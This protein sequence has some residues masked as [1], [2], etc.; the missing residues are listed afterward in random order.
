[1]RYLNL[2]IWQHYSN[3]NIQYDGKIKNIQQI[4]MLSVIIAVSFVAESRAARIRPK[5]FI[6][7]QIE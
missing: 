7:C 4:K 5:V 6:L 1:M 2:S 3:M